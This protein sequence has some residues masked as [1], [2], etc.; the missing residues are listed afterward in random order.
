MEARKAAEVRV[1]V[2]RA[3][4]GAEGGNS[5]GESLRPLPGKTTD[6][7]RVTCASINKFGRHRPRAPLT[8]PDRS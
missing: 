6:G 4:N 5:H 3:A 2:S 1:F 8:E 7:T